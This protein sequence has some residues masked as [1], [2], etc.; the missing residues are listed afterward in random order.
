MVNSLKSSLPSSK[1]FTFFLD[2]YKVAF[3][4]ALIPQCLL[5]CPTEELLEELR[6]FD[7]LR[8]I[9]SGTISSFW[10]MAHLPPLFMWMKKHDPSLYLDHIRSWDEYTKSKMSLLLRRS[11]AIGPNFITSLL[12]PDFSTTVH[13]IKEILVD[14]LDVAIVDHFVD[15]DDNTFCMMGFKYGP[16]QFADYHLMISQFLADPRRSGY[17][18]VD[19]DRFT[20]LTTRFTEYLL[21]H[22]AYV[23]FHLYWP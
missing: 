3:Y 16:E 22:S 19:G 5:A 12:L 13:D 21:K 1:M 6:K 15:A 2:S 7:I 20:R 4:S 18:H 17:F 14:G 11:P 8:F 9:T 23:Q 10:I